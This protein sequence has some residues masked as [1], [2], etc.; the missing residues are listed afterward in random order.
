VEFMEKAVILAAEEFL[1]RPYP[2]KSADAYLLLTFD[3]N[4]TEE[5]ERDYEE[6]AGICLEHGAFDVLISNTQ[7]RNESIWKARGAF[8]EAIKSSTTEMDECDVVVPRSRVADFINYSATLEEK[9]GIRIRS[10]GHAGD[11]NLHIYILRDDLPQALWE[12]KLSRVFDALYSKAEEMGGQVSGEHG[13]GYVKR[14]YLHRAAGDEQLELMSR[15]KMAF[16]PNGIL[17]PGKVF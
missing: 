15:I 12:E 17:N 10:F 13:I 5:I 3:G 2:D 4:S 16:D 14:P 7:E 6:V 9:F 1:G 8:L 11:G